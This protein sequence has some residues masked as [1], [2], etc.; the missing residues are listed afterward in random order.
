MAKKDTNVPV[1]QCENMD[2]ELLRRQMKRLEDNMVF[3]KEELEKIKSNPQQPAIMPYNP[4]PAEPQEIIFPDNFAKSEDIRTMS[5]SID[6]LVK[7][8]ALVL[9][10]MAELKK[11]FEKMPK[12]EDKTEEI[13]SKASE[14]FASKVT[15]D[16]KP[17]IE[18]GH[19]VSYYNGQRQYDGIS[20]KDAADIY[21]QINGLRSDTDL[22]GKLAKRDKAIRIM[23]V[24]ILG[25]V[26][27]LV[28]MG[29]WL[30][31]VKKENRELINVEWLY[32][33]KRAISSD[34]K[35]TDMI[36]KDML[37]KDESEK[38]EWK[39]LIVE[40]ESSGPEFNFFHPHDDWKPKTPKEE[41]KSEDKS[42]ASSQSADSK[43]S[44]HKPLPHEQKSRLTPGEIAAYKF[45]QNDPNIPK[46]AKPQ[47]PEEYE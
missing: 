28:G 21:R 2:M 42:Q 26:G 1:E 18:K 20:V 5:G 19:K 44:E 38:E 32:R 40:R 43:Q 14:A 34:A 25:L 47:L 15:A 10:G 27:I 46:D 23:A 37:G 45:L 36:E 16:L 9:Q 24:V 13:V 22:K 31:A 6:N 8:V 29:F 30:H 4:P 7:T 35:F 3:I 41:S 17:S 33:A 11:A 12:P 39:S